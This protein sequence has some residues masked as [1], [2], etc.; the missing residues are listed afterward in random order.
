MN[1]EKNR[2]ATSQKPDPLSALCQI[3]FE[4]C[5]SEK[6]VGCCLCLSDQSMIASA[7]AFLAISAYSR[8]F[9]C[10]STHER[11]SAT[12]RRGEGFSSKSMVGD[13]DWLVPS[14]VDVDLAILLTQSKIETQKLLR[15][16]HEVSDNAF[17][18]SL[19]LPPPKPPLLQQILK[20]IPSGRQCLANVSNEEV[21]LLFHDPCVISPHDSKGASKMRSTLMRITS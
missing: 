21:R 20:T 8:E 6:S 18:H 12:N 15:R 14:P 4:S 3:C 9:W 1:F 7:E 2:L 13:C 17:E 5:S 10:A 16:Q 11:S 19:E